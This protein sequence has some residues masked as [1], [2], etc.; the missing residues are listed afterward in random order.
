MFAWCRITPSGWSAGGEKY[1]SLDNRRILRTLKNAQACFPEQQWGWA[2]PTQDDVWL[3]QRT[4]CLGSIFVGL[5]CGPAPFDP[6]TAQRLL[7]LLYEKKLGV[8]L[9]ELLEHG[10]GS[11]EIIVVDHVLL[12]VH[13]T[14]TDI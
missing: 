1:F 6:K 2:V 13:T 14:K 9:L 5:D 7:A 12:K 4:A 3:P 10:W 8:R 11:L